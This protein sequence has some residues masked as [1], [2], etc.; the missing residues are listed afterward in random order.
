MKK[1]IQY[2]LLLLLFLAV[3]NV[4]VFAQEPPAKQDTFFLAKKKGVLG[5]LGRSISTNPPDKEPQKIENPFLQ[6]KGKYI[7]KVMMVSLGFGT[8]VYDTTYNSQNF[9]T[10]IANALHKNT[11]AKVI[12]RNLFF[13]PGSPVYPYLLAD[14]ERYLRQLDYIQDARILIKPV[15]PGKDSVDVIIITKDVFSI[16]GKVDI[17]SNKRGRVDF[18]EENIT[19]SGNQ[20]LLSGFYDKDRRPNQGYGAELIQRNIGGSFINWTTGYKNFNPSFSDGHY[21]ETGMYSRLEKPLVTPYIPSTGSIEA[22]YYKTSDAY[23]SSHLYN[24]Y[25]KYGYYNFDTWFGYSLDS[26]RSIYANREIRLHR[27]IA[28]RGFL[29]HF[30]SVPDTA[31]ITYDYRFANVKGALASLYI[32]RQAFY[33]TSFIYGFGV[34]EDV[35]EGFSASV[36]TG[37]INKQNT[38]RPYGGLEFEVNSFKNRGFHSTFTFRA[39][40][41]FN[42]NRFEDANI[43]VNIEHFT[44]LRRLS[45]NWFQRTFVNAGVTTQVNPLLDGPLVLNSDFGLPYFN[46]YNLNSDMRYTVKAESTFYNTDKLLGF[47]FAPFV[48]ADM[49]ALKPTRQAFSKID[50]YSAIGGGVRT[51]N[52]NLTF[53]TVE[54]RGYFFPRALGDMQDWKI[55]VNS[56]IRFRYNSSF[57]RRPDFIVAN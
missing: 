32:F 36:T 54:L 42:R 50:M 7:R 10:R 51:R 41:F 26:K 9:G 55:E 34:N 6:Y 3:T 53:G 1:K 31:R 24:R 14:N 49:S 18:K 25:Y 8:S 30:T 33:K 11:K 47:R 44:R 48:F 45:S 19:G 56:N 43:L 17:A 28:V 38:V 39:G 23:D 27:F 5:R 37:I 13:R 20:I 35:P 52:E 12:Y 15:T 29:Q 57:I 4:K 2:I 21:Q 16:G 46:N 40:G 22:S